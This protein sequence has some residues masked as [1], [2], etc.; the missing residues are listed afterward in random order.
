[1]VKIDQ[2]AASSGSWDLRQSSRVA[3]QLGLRVVLG[4]ALGVEVGLA[5]PALAQGDAAAGKTVFANQCASCHTTVP[6]KNGF[7]PSL[8]GVIDRKS[9][10]LAGFRY[11]PAMAQAGLTWDQKTLDEFLTSSTKKV[12][13]SSMPV[14]LANAD[15][16]SNVIAYLETLGHASAAEAKAPATHAELMTQGPTQDELLHA[17]QD[18]ANWLYA[19]KDYAGTR[20]VDLHQITPA[21]AR[22]LRAACIF[23]STTTGATQSNLLVYRGVMYLTIDNAI[24]A[25]DAATCREKWTYIWAAVLS[26]AN[27]GVALKDG[28]AVRGTAD[29]YLIAVDM[30]KGTLL[31]SQ[32][33]A[34]P[35]TSQYLSMP[36]LI[37]DDLVI[38]GPAGADWGARQQWPTPLVAGVTVTSGGMLFTGDL[39]DNFLAIDASNGKTLYRFNT[40]GS[41]G[42]GVISYSVDGKQYVATTSGVVS[43]FFGGSGPSAVMVFALP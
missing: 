29:G 26:P 4:L 14:A 40:G 20:F 28:R 8:A 23:R 9:G 36:P 10:T 3:A 17:A 30:A 19:S 41:I 22:Q 32:K 38:Y 15:D 11:S 12:P 27:R 5:G 1:M 25:I 21:N 43:G 37:Y 35:S 42:G 16:R 31:W 39:D 13:G 18:T 6:G 2:A 34:D 7:G 33:I 24:V